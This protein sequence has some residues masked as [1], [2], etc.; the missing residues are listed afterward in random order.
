VVAGEWWVAAEKWGWQ[1]E[2]CGRQ[3][4]SGGGS[5]KIGGLL[6]VHVFTSDDL[7]KQRYLEFKRDN[8]TE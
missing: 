6:R 8:V 3:L 7:R 2:N 1:L 4:G 5:W